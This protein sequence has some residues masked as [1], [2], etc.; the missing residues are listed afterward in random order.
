MSKRRGRRS[1]KVVAEGSLLS[2]FDTDDRE[3]SSVILTLPA[4]GL[5]LVAKEESSTEESSSDI[6][7]DD[8]PVDK[9][10]SECIK[11]DMIISQYQE[12]L[13]DVKKESDANKLYFINNPRV[14]KSD[15][16]NHMLKKTKT[17]CWFHTRPHTF[18][19]CP[20][21]DDK[22]GDKW[23]SIGSFCSPCCALGYNFYVIKDSRV[24]EREALTR[25]WLREVCN[26][27][28][29]VPLEI[30]V[31]KNWELLE[32][33]GGPMTVEQFQENFYFLDKSKAPLTEPKQIT[34]DNRKHEPD[35][36]DH[37]ELLVYRSK[38]L[39]KPKSIMRS[40]NKK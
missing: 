39:Y 13:K 34:I 26:I 27:P 4:K 15:G 16:K 24:Y 32:H 14:I 12:R 8:I 22:I 11:K 7:Y 29:H 31:A 35:I 9:T 3:Q 6:F 5:S 33:R 25:Q 20:L 38:P 18:I 28:I 36:A 1:N 40:L 37:T 30:I 17:D 2:S 10:C 23:V 21:I 19:E